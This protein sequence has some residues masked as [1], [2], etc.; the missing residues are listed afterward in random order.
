MARTTR[1]AGRP[2]SRPVRP[3]KP[4]TPGPGLLPDLARLQ[5]AA[6]APPC[7]GR[8]TGQKYPQAFRAT[9]TEHGTTYPA[10]CPRP[11]ESLPR[12]TARL[13]AAD[14]PT[15]PAGP[16]S[17]VVAT[18]TR[19]LALRPCPPAPCQPL[20]VAPCRSASQNLPRSACLVP[21]LSLL[22]SPVRPPRTSL[23]PRMGSSPSRALLA[24][25]AG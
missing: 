24:F 20:P 10:T 6:G 2:S 25:H 7:R 8:A 5:P 1:S 18:T 17:G 14:H 15:S 23:P 11:E 4:R 13:N 19:R 12:P 22:Y 9:L 16:S 3:V 21:R